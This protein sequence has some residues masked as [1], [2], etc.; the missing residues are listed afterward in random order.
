MCG[1]RFGWRKASK[2]EELIRRVQCRLKFLKIKRRSIVKQLREDIVELL[3]N[4]KPETAFSHAEELFKDQSLFSV[5]DL[6]DHFCEFLILHLPYIRKHR[7]YPNDINEAVSTLIFAAAW[8]GDLPELHAVRKLFRERHGSKFI[9]AI[10][11]LHPGNHVNSQVVKEKLC[12]KS[13]PDDMKLSLI[14]ELAKDH[15]LQAQHHGSNKRLGSNLLLIWGNDNLHWEGFLFDGMN[16]GNYCSS[17]IREMLPA[18]D[19]DIVTKL[20]GQIVV[21]GNTVQVEDRYESEMVCNKLSELQV[22]FSKTSFNLEEVEEIHINT[23]QDH[24]AGDKSIFLFNSTLLSERN[25]YGFCG[26]SFFVSS[27]CYNDH[28]IGTAPAWNLTPYE[29]Q[30][31]HGICPQRRNSRKIH[32]KNPLPGS[33]VT[34]GFKHEASTELWRMKNYKKPTKHSVVEFQNDN[35]IENSSKFGEAEVS[36]FPGCCVTSCGSSSSGSSPCMELDIIPHQS[37]PRSMNQ[38]SEAINSSN[39]KHVHPKLPDYDE[40]VAKFNALKQEHQQRE[41]ASL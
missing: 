24:Y 18:N 22:Q 39:Y 35:L 2:C 30:I 15:A 11:E 1:I 13:I 34:H 33:S 3:R 7:N 20:P 9:K 28:Y 25:N 41:A 4:G 23:L 29:E 6:L 36:E 19:K 21:V 5:Y 8:C 37:Y 14:V 12:L 16:Q 31:Y 38:N 26:E 10:T 32:S 17:W 27:Q 40:L